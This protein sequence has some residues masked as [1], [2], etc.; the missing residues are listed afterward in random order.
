MATSFS[1]QPIGRFYSASQPVKRP[2]EFACFSYDDNHEFHLDDSSMRYYYNPTIGA[3]L[4]KGYDTF[5]KADESGDEHLVSLLKTIQAHEQKSG[6]KIDAQ[7]VTWRGMMTKIMSTPFDD[8]DGFEMNATLYQVRRLSQPSLEQA[9]WPDFIEENNA[10][11]KASQQQQ[12]AQQRRGP[13]APEVM[14]FWGYKFETLATLPKPWGDT[15]REYIENREDEVVNNKA[16]YCSVVRTGIGATT[17]CIGGEVDAIWDSKPAQ[18]GTPINWVELKTSVDIRSDRDAATFDRKL[19]KFWLQSFLL[20]VPRI[21][22]GFRTHAGILARVQEIQ[23]A[24]IPDTIARRP[25]PPWNGDMCVNFAGEFLDWLRQTINDDG[26]WR[27]RRKPGSPTI[28]VFRIEE[29]GHGEILT[30]EFINW[31]IKLSLGPPPAGTE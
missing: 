24:E 25:N 18:P 17:I 20:G 16:Q 6:Q 7:L 9:P 11:K 4:S 12:N 1:I 27:I 3:D 26:V 5:V 2:K 29:A 8:R 23:T 13:H 31:R 10:Y 30:D 22:V 21:I 19:L 28:E 14:Q 15:P